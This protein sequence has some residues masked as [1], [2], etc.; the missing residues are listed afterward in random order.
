[1]I[2]TG[3]TNYAIG[4]RLAYLEVRMMLALLV[5][6]FAFKKVEEQLDSDEAIESITTSPKYCFVSLQKI[7]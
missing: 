7:R 4:K 3:W 5:W 6:N 2:E 1:M